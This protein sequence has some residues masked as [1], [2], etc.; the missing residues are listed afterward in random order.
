LAYID[1]ARSGAISE[2][3]RAEVRLR[4]LPHHVFRAHVVRIGIESDRVNE[5]RRVFVKCEQCPA[6]FHLG[7]Q[8]EVLITVANLAKATLVPEA[9]VIG[10]DGSKG[11]A[12][13]LESGYL[14]RR[15]VSVGYHTEDARL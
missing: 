9:A 4:S 1:E 12:W 7:E 14:K 13:T 6:R 5:E 8:A 3:Q 2:G 10:Y 11:A 15:V